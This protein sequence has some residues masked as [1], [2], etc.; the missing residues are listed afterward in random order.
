MVNVSIVE[1]PLFQFPKTF[2]G[3]LFIGADVFDSESLT[4][5]KTVG[6]MFWMTTLWGQVLVF[7]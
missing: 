2:F 6:A 3:S 7:R 1:T 4:A 5:R